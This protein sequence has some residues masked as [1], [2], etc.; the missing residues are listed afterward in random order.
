MAAGVKGMSVVKSLNPTRR[1]SLRNRL[2]ECGGIEGWNAALAKVRASDF[3]RGDNDRGWIADFD[4]LLQQKSF[5]KLMEGAYDN[6]ARGGKA[7][8]DD[9]YRGVEI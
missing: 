5:T 9:A 7:M 6:R 1:K 3:L 4:F 8:R 2:S